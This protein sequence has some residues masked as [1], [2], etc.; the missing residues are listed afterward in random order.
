M[1]LRSLSSSALLA[2]ALVSPAVADTPPVTEDITVI[3]KKLDEARNSIQ[4]QTGA[5]TYVIDGQALDNQPGGTDNPLNQVLLQAPGVAQDSFGQIHIRGEHNNL[6]YRLNG[7]IL[8]EG[9]S[10]FGQTLKD[11]KSVV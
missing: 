1:L 3:G 8:P 6:Q 11:R 5:S 10:V 7:I 4:T 9:I 2:A